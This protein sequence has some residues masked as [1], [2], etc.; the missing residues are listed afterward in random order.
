MT[1]QEQTDSELEREVMAS[2]TSPIGVHVPEHSHQPVTTK[3]SLDFSDG[4]GLIRIQIMVSTMTDPAIS[5]REIQQTRSS[6]T[7]DPQIIINDEVNSTE[8]SL[9]SLS[10]QL[11]SKTE[12][13]D[14]DMTA[15]GDAHMEMQRRPSTS[16]EDVQVISEKPVIYPNRNSVSESSK[17]NKR[18]SKRSKNQKSRIAELKTHASLDGDSLIDAHAELQIYGEDLKDPKNEVHEGTV[19]LNPSQRGL[20]K[21]KNQF[22][23]AQDDSQKVKQAQKELASVRGA[24]EAS[25]DDLRRTHKELQKACKNLA[26]SQDELT[27]CKDEL[28]RLQPIAQTPDSKVAKEFENLCSQIVNW[29]E[30]EVVIF[31][32]AHPGNGPEYI[33]LI[34][35]DRK[36]AQFMNQHPRSG[37]HLATHMIHYWLQVHIFRQKVSCLGLPAEATQLLERAEHS[38][39]RLVPPRGDSD[40]L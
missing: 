18:T 10:D 28:F 34:G 9:V 30:A 40:D 38:M 26:A 35:E 24:L 7:A 8:I 4:Q 25:Q 29:I 20:R 23:H 14:L 3:E 27:A 12:A 21:R 32:K 33:F 17:Q 15:E 6:Q 2:A 36:A 39:A 22:S 19:Q 1:K 5:H 37:E 11:V 13:K 31:E 16:S